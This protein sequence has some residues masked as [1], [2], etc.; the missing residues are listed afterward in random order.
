M[1]LT[2]ETSIDMQQQIC[3]ECG[4]ASD[5]LITDYRHNVNNQMVVVIKN[6]EHLC[7]NCA[8]RRKYYGDLKSI[9]ERFINQAKNN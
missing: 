7:G 9:N 2:L 3:T 8:S 6:D 5:V 1:I 4:V